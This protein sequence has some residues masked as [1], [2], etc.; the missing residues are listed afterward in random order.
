MP[1]FRCLCG[2]GLELGRFAFLQRLAF[3]ATLPHDREMPR[4]ALWLMLLL[5]PAIAS[6][7]PRWETLPLPPAM[8]AASTTGHVKVSEGAQIYYATFG[9]GDPVVLLHGG[10]GNSDHWAFQ[11][12]ELAAKYQVIVIDS[13][14]Q[15]RSTLHRTK[16]KLSYQAMATDVIAVL[17][18]L[19]IKK[20]A[21][22]GWSDGGAIALDLG[23][24]HADRV[25]KLFVFGTNY[26]AKGSKDRK[27]GSSATFNAYAV[28]CKNDYVKMAKTP[29]EFGAVVESLMAVWTSTTNFTKDQL[30]GIKAYTVVADGAHDEII[31]LEQVEEMS[32]LIPNAKLVVFE[33][34]SHFALWQDP[35]AFNKAVLEFM[36]H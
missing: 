17:D 18:I 13:R 30:R 24:R 28:K 32:Q 3:V 25:S 7:K 12:P 21:V 34:A 20:T 11:V 26:D 22:I 23:I 1:D 31:K 10:L 8:P 14:N 9:K 33:N 15:G 29:R 36:A 35:E 2:D 27:A 6:A 16:T 19:G 5:V 4:A